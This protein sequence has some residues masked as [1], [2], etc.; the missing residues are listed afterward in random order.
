MSANG[1]LTPNELAPIA[2]G[3]LAKPAAAGWNAMNVEA[4]KEGIELVPTA[5]DCSYRTYEQQVHYWELFKSGKGNLAAQPGHSNHGLGMA[6]DIPTPAMRAKVDEIGRAYGWSKTWSDAQSEVW[7]YCY[8]AGHYSGPDPGP[9]GTGHVTAPSGHAPV[10]P[11]PRDHYLGQPSAAPHCHSGYHGGVDNTNVGT[12][13]SRMR[14]RGYQLDA[15]GK[16][17][18]NSEKAARALQSK[19]GLGVDGRVGPQTWAATWAAAST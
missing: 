19:V 7:H 2:G 15:D 3:Q 8:Q 16:F 18:P 1:R 13:Q 17:G 4:R 5:F 12:W 10:F 9:H 11:Y 6:V 14:D